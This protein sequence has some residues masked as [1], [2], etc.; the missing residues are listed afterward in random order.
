MTTPGGV[1]IMI[2]EEGVTVEGARIYSVF[3]E[4]SKRKGREMFSAEESMW[5]RHERGFGEKLKVLP[6]I[7]SQERWSSWISR[8]QFLC[9][10]KCPDHK[11]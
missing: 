2:L 4:V 3:V 10:R 1:L 8:E 9:G 7:E 5:L 11:V 6:Y